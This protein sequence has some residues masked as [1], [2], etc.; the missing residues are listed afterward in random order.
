MTGLELGSEETDVPLHPS[1]FPQTFQLCPSLMIN[2]PAFTFQSE[3]PPLTVAMAMQTSPLSIKRE[4][5]SYFSFTVKEKPPQKASPECAPDLPVLSAACI[6]GHSPFP[7]GTLPE[8][9][10]LEQILPLLEP[11]TLEPSEEETTF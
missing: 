4:K 5:K 3:R 10:H 7:S 9:P 8:F 11:A 2:E 6:L 1:S